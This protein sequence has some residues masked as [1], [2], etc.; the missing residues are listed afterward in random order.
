MTGSAM[1]LAYWLR[2]DFEPAMQVLDF[3]EA[4]FSADL[5]KKY[6]ILI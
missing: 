1:R 4:G 3:I 5:E 6:K 2:G